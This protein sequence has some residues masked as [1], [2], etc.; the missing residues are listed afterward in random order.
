MLDQQ[1]R[2]AALVAD[3]ADELAELVDLVVIEAAGRLVEQ[4]QLRLGRERA[5]QLDALLRAEGQ[6]GDA[7][8]A[9][10][11]E[12][13]IGDQI[14]CD[15]AVDAAPRAAHPGQAQRVADEVAAGAGMGA[16]PDVVEHRQMRRN[17]ARFWKVRPMPIS[18]MPV[19]RPR[20]DARAL[21]QD[22]AGRLGV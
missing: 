6:A 21:E 12:V 5:R 17:S 13:E 9:T 1:H 2:D 4:Q 7:A 14:S 22:V 10:S 11:L 19:R 20:Q 15:L 18:A 3:A 8:C 16:D